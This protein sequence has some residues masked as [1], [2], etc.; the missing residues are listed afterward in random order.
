MSRHKEQVRAFC[1]TIS[2]IPKASKRLDCTQIHMKYPQDP[3]YDHSSSF[4]NH[5]N[6][7]F[8]PPSWLGTTFI[9]Q[10][11]LLLYH[12]MTLPTGGRASQ[13]PV[14]PALDFS[15]CMCHPAHFPTIGTA[16]R[17]RR[18]IIILSIPQQVDPAP[19][20]RSPRP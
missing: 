3:D 18:Y 6:S 1:P 15:A 16:F 13:L 10:H 12:S 11:R 20:A 17:P 5:G 8:R 9:L 14:N 7:L 4:Q 2:R 19:D